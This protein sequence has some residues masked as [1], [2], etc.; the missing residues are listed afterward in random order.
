[1]FKKADFFRQIFLQ[2][3]FLNLNINP[4]S[5][6]QARAAHQLLPIA[7]HMLLEPI[8]RLLN[9]QPQRQRCGKLERFYAREKKYYHKNAPC[10]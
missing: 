10:Y 6:E 3:Y 5:N 7:L 1:V 2:K 8:L 9:L 4:W